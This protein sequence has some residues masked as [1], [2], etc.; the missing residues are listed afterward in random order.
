MSTIQ[1]FHEKAVGSR[2][3]NI[4]T[5]AFVFYFSFSQLKRIRSPQV[6]RRM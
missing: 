2:I 1:G 5:L 4:L 3:G 6:Q